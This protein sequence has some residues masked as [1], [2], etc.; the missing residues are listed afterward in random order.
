MN[1]TEL[2]QQQDESHIQTQVMESTST[3][4]YQQ[5]GYHNVIHRMSDTTTCPNAP[6]KIQYTTTNHRGYSP[7]CRRK[8][9]TEK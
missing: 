6:C 2:P 9:F 4:Y 7:L 8:L 5:L 1:P 3:T